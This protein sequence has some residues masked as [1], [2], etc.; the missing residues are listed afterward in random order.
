MAYSELEDALEMTRE[1]LEETEKE[2][3]QED[4]L[5]ALDNWETE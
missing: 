5:E 3:T 2:F 1:Y 4:M